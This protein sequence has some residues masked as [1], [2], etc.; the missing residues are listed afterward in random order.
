MRRLRIRP[1]SLRD[2]KYWKVAHAIF[3]SLGYVL[4]NWLVDLNIRFPG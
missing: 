1:S 2:M 3:E 4:Y